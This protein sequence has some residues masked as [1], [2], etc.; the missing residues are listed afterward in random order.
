MYTGTF[1]Y[2]FPWSRY[3]SIHLLISYIKDIGAK[4]HTTLSF[5][6][7]KTHTQISL[8]LSQTHTHTNIHRISLSL[9]LSLTH[10]LTHKLYLTNSLT[11]SLSHTNTHTHTHTL[12][13]EGIILQ[14]Q[15]EFPLV[16]HL[17]DFR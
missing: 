11:S 4:R 17:Q 13:C 10:T 12:D 7:T 1:R 9:S 16:R 5:F 14:R 2:V 6:Y 3:Q 15:K 8:S